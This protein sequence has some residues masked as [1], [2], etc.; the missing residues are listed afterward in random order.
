MSAI[1]QEVEVM[2]DQ[3]NPPIACLDWCIGT[4]YVGQP[5]TY[6]IYPNVVNGLG[7]ATYRGIVAVGQTY[8]DV[9]AAGLGD[10]ADWDDIGTGCIQAR[11]DWRYDWGTET[12]K[13]IGGNSGPVTLEWTDGS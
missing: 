5:V 8:I 11:D 13:E 1:T 9:T 10:T 6:N 4:Y 2:A 12:W 7:M 3:F